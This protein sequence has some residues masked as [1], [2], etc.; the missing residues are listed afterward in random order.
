MGSIE[1]RPAGSEDYD[2]IFNVHCAAMHASVERVFGWDQD[3]QARYFREQFDTVARQIIRHDGAE[4]GSIS[5]EEKSTGFV[6]NSI[7][8]LPEYQGFGIGTSLIR[9]L[10]QRASTRGLPVT[11]QVLRGNP[12][13]RLYER[14]GFQVIGETDTHYRMK[15][16][17]R[18]E[19]GEEL[20]PHT[21]DGR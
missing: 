2:F 14:M 20:C 19:Q 16:H 8:I 21:T 18:F 9:R 15:W 5:V 1:L 13:L 4:I 6:L 17:D 3:W 7:A 10:Q 11:L 12:A